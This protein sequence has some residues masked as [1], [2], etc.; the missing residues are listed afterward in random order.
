MIGISSTSRT[1]QTQYGIITSNVELVGCGNGIFGLLDGFLQVKVGSPPINAVLLLGCLD[2]QI[3]DI[4][5]VY[6]Q[7]WK[8]KQN[9]K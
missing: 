1:S 9:N 6:A 3:D 5:N 7:S 2:N 8:Q 4:W